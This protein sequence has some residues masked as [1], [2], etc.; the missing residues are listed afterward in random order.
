M[1]LKG[2]DEEMVLREKVKNWFIRKTKY[3]ENMHNSYAM[4]LVQCTKLLRNKLQV[5]NIGKN[6]SKTNQL[7]YL[8]Q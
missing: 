8:R 6:I 4:I 7:V 1:P 2:S 5:K 3:D